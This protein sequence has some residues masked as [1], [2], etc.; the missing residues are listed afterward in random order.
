VGGASGYDIVRGSVTE[1]RAM[2]GDFSDPLVTQSCLRNNW[3][4]TYLEDS[5]DPPADEGYW[6]LVRGQPSGTYDTGASSQ[7]APRD[8]AIAASGNGCP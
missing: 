2:S 5:L 4:A 8:A 3:S 6:F 7:V 1:L